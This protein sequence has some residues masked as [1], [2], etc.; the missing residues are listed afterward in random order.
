MRKKPGTIIKNITA[1]LTEQGPMT[2]SELCE[3]MKLDKDEVSSVLSRMKLKLPKRPQRVHVIGYT[4]DAEGSR[5][6]PRAIYAIGEGDNAEHPKPDKKA[7]RRRYD[8]NKKKK[9]NS[10]WMLGANRETRKSLGFPA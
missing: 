9:I 5:R 8:A 6:Y 3:A 4:H 2:T 7:I 1:I 10:V